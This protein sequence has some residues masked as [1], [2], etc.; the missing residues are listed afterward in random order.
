MGASSLLNTWLNTQ[1]DNSAKTCAG[2]D[3]H[4]SAPV[5]LSSSSNLPFMKIILPLFIRP[6]L[7]LS[8][9]LNLAL[10]STVV[11][12]WNRGNEP[13]QVMVQPSAKKTPEARAAKPVP[14]FFQWTQLEARDFATFVKN[15][16]SIGCPELTIRD[17]IAGE[18]AEIYEQKRQIVASSSSSGKQL[19]DA[20]ANINAEQSRLLADLTQ[21]ES[22]SLAAQNLATSANILQQEPKTTNAETKPVLDIPVAFTYGS[23]GAAV[24][25]ERGNK[26]LVSNDSN[27]TLPL[28]TANSLAAIKNE[29]V[30]SVGGTQ[31]PASEA[32]RL[33]WQQARMHANERFSSMFGGDALVR[34]QVE[35]Q[36][37]GA[38]AVTP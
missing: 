16:R 20:L 17:I 29:F 27:T 25:V 38:S 21:F 2:A 3:E 26:T 7:P 11:V 31:D 23:L 4:S 9:L 36:H 28:A 10:C 13:H 12:L 1:P 34:A 15:L 33:R 24:V 30:Q 14:S 8:L 5:F 18:L 6:L 37:P 35:A 32:Y 19:A 22:K